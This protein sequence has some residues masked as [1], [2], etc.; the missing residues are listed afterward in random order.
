MARGGFPGMGGGNM[1]Q[2]MMKAQRMQQ[3]MQ[4]ALDDIEARSFTA[5]AGGGVVSVTM[6]G[7][8]QLQALS[9]KPEA[10]DK[11]DV[12]MLQ[13]LIIAAVNEALHQVEDAT[14]SATARL[15]GGMNIPGL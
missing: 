6:T 13:D 5:S 15:T 12:E 4:K 9:I 14:Q 8:R 7:K 11:D 10:L 2:M 3:E 1:Q